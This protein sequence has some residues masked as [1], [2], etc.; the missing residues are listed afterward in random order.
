MD[1][2][3]QKNNKHLKNV[4]HGRNDWFDFLRIMASFAVIFSHV[5]YNNWSN[6]SLL[7]L[8]LRWQLANCA[9][10]LFCW[11]VGVFVLLSG[12]A[13]MM[14]DRTITFKYMFKKAV[15]L[16]M[17]LVVWN[18]FYQLSSMAVTGKINLSE[19][20]AR[21]LDMIKGYPYY[22]LW[23]LCT[24]PAIYILVV[25]LRK[26]LSLL[27]K[28]GAYVFLIAVFLCLNVLPFVLEL[29]GKNILGTSAWTK[30]VLYIP[31]FAYGY[32]ISKYPP[33]KPLRTAIYFLGITGLVMIPVFNTL[34]LPDKPI[35][36]LVFGAPNSP[37]NIL[38]AAAIVLFFKKVSEKKVMGEKLLK[39][40]SPV[41]ECCFGIYLCHDAF[42]IVSKTLFGTHAINR[43]SLLSE[44]PASL[45][46]FLL[47]FLAI[48][49]LR[50]IPFMKKIT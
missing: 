5:I 50:K 16:L 41:K 32:I 26:I 33:S 38:V 48:Y 44:I 7:P 4:Q 19:F 46:I 29:S 24:L 15:R 25:P 47:S 37:S 28:A 21:M 8:S 20:S 30:S 11:C 2:I 23:F 9:S 42:I 3:H 34:L 10:S 14:P 40:V 17:Y 31:L 36:V 1:K 43:F 45:I 22:H 12:I 27:N 6:K 13:F 18:L 35:T 39:F 49:T